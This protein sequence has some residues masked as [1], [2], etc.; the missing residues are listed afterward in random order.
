M[1]NDILIYMNR[2]V[3][4]HGT[5]ISLKCVQRCS[6]KFMARALY[7]LK[8]RLH[9]IHVVGYKYPGRATCIRIQVNTTCIR[10][11]VSGV[12]AAL[13]YRTLIQCMSTRD[14]HSTDIL[15]QPISTRA[16]AAVLNGPLFTSSFI[17]WSC[18]FHP[19]N[20]DLLFQQAYCIFSAFHF[21][22]PGRIQMISDTWVQGFCLPAN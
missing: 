19:C 5:S 8:P 21:G 3:S 14:Q 20:L 18:S 9:Q 17:F 7:S 6:S 10:L 22:E 12:N 13:Q 16:S 1:A 11:H 15:L 2:T 4:R